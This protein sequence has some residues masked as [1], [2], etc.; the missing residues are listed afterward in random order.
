[1]RILLDTCAFLWIVSGADELSD[2]A[3]ELF[4]ATEHEV[5]LSSVSAWEI[6]AKHQ[7]GKLAI[8]KLPDLHRD[9]F[10]RMLVCQAMVHGMTILTPDGLVTQYPVRCV[11]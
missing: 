7:L 10:D 2:Q 5:V 4:C 9:P 11:W 6:A 8:H 1:M 3:R